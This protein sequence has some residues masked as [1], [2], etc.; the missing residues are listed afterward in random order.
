MHIDDVEHTNVEIREEICSLQISRELFSEELK[1]CR[2]GRRRTGDLLYTDW[3]ILKESKMRWKNL[4]IAWI[5]Y[6]NVYD[7]IL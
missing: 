4:A 5:D 7:M 3:H 1:G 2:K 6:K